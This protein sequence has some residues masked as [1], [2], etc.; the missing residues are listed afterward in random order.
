MAKESK[1]IPGAV[2]KRKNAL[3]KN[4]EAQTTGPQG[5]R[6]DITEMQD[7]VKWKH[8]ETKSRF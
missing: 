6:S 2:P 5:H 1:R 4:S 3:S 8:Q 7:R